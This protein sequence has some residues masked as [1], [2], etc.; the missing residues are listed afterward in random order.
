[1]G[2]RCCS[3]CGGSGTV[4]EQKRGIC[5]GCNGNRYVPS[6][7]DP[8]QGDRSNAPAGQI[9]CPRCHGSGHGDWQYVDAR[10]NTCLGSGTIMVSDSTEQTSRR[11]IRPPPPRTTVTPPVDEA[12]HQ[13]GV[14]ALVLVATV[15]LTLYTH[16]S[17]HLGWGTALWKSG[18]FSFAMGVIWSVVAASGSASW[19]LFAIA[20]FGSYRGW[21]WFFHDQPF[22]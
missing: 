6:H 8:Y 4:R 17:M 20:A 9:N 15:A 5:G 10:C 14:A 11:P 2:N 13:R 21:H 1:M 12:D 18:I 7:V 3:S 22:F 19:I 16:F